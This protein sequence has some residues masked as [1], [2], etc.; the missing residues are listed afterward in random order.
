MNENLIRDMHNEGFCGNFGAHKTKDLVE[1]NYYWL[2]MSIYEKKWV[3]HYKIYQHV[4]GRS[5]NIE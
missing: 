3:E 2:G 1:D 5:Q 4:K